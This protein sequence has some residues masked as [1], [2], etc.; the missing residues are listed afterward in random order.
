MSEMKKQLLTLICSIPSVFIHAQ[1]IYSNGGTLHVSTGGVLYCNGG[2]TLSNATQLTNQGTLTATKNS[3]FAQPGNFEINS[4]SIVSGNGIYRVEQDWINDATFNGNAGEVILFG[5]TEQLITSTTGTMTTFNNLTLSGNGT[6]TNRRKTLVNVNATTGTT[7]V[8]NLNDRELHTGIHLFMVDNTAP[9]AISNATTFN[10]EGFVSSSTNGFLIRKTNQQTDYLFPVGSSDG[11]RRYRPVMM[12]PNTAAEQVYEVR[13]NNFSADNENYFL[14]QHES[15]ID[16]VNPLFFHS[17]DRVS[18]TSDP[19]IKLF[20]VPAADNDWT[21][22]A[23]WYGSEQQWKDVTNTSENTSGNFKFIQKNS[24]GFP[25]SHF[26]YALINTTHP[27]SIPN[28]FTPNGDGVNDVFFITSSGL[29][30]FNLFIVNRWGELVFETND[31]NQ[32]WDGTVNG[33]KCSDGVYF[34]SLKAKQNTTDVV[35]HGHITI[36]GNK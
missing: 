1:T 9:T 21:S 2:I 28:V 7:G 34:Y 13:F 11:T 20:F 6:N 35:K 29:T 8:L 12:N 30:D 25:T 23:H 32:A 15:T 19:D 4:N 22:F 18:G 36:N 24:W 16:V 26:Q 3:T 17:I 10:N 5:N 31:P 27:F 14:A 33:N